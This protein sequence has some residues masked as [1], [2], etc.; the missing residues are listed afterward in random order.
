VHTVHKYTATVSGTVTVNELHWQRNVEVEEFKTLTNADWNYP[1]DARIQGR[2]NRIRTYRTVHDGWHSETYTDME[3]RYRTV[4]YTD[5]ETRYR[6]E[7]YSG[8]CTR[9]VSGGNG[10]FRS[11]TYSCPQTRMTSYTVPVQKTRQESYTVP[12]QKTRQVEDTHQEPVWDT[13]YTY[14]VDRWVTDHW[15]TESD[16]TSNKVIWPVPNNINHNNVAGDQIGEERVGD[17]RNESYDVIYSDS[18]AKKHSDK[19]AYD[20][21]S[22]LQKDEKVPATYMQHNGEMKSVDWNSVLKPAA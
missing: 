16:A 6:T 14:Q 19:V 21:W 15:V 9:M 3:T 20:L 18:Q 2:E 13:W 7:T 22:K 11:E 4:S 10:S 12:V 1:G 8:T 17:E 5:M